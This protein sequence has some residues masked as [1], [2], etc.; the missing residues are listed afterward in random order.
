MAHDDMI[1]A[2]AYIDQLYQNSYRKDMIEDDW[3]PQD[4]AMGY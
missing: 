1:D 3:E 2:L 4:I